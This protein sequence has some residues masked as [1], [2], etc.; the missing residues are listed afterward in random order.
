MERVLGTVVRDG[1]V[2]LAQVV[3]SGWDLGCRQVI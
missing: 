3:D 2:P 1:E